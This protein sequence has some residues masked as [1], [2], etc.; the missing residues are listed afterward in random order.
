[1]KSE[2]VIP[3]RPISK[4]LQ[5][6]ID[7]HNARVERIW[8][9]A[10]SRCKPANAKRAAHGGSGPSWEPSAACRIGQR[11]GLGSVGSSASHLTNSYR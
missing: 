3:V 5:E 4:P 2:I 6:L 9:T 11:D 10:G 1:M 7:E 8:L